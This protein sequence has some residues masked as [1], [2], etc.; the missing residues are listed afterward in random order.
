[1][2]TPIYIPSPRRGWAVEIY[3]TAEAMGLEP[4]TLHIPKAGREFRS[5]GVSIDDLNPDEKVLIFPTMGGF[6][7]GSRF[8]ERWRNRLRW[9]LDEVS[10]R[11]FWD[12]ANLIHPT[13]HLSPTV[14]LGQGVFIGPLVSVS[15]STKIGDY[16]L[17]G[18][19][20]SVGHDVDIGPFGR[21]GPGVVIPSGVR[22]ED[23]VTIGPGVTFINRITVG[24]E[25]LV[26][27]GSV[28][29][30]SVPSGSFVLGVPARPPRLSKR[31]RFLA[32]WKGVLPPFLLR[33]KGS[34]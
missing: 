34:R 10:A 29:T 4:I 8:D 3:E 7:G 18:R 15:S 17:I 1:V 12:F 13:A 31:K 24:S 14:K 28:V 6:A 23:S 25:S 22:L 21:L 32:W 11:G 19:S 26:G 33:E 27:A 9:T 30:K 2:S 5:L 16:S 20:C